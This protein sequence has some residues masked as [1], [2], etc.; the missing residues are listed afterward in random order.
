MKIAVSSTGNDMNSQVDPRFGRCNCFLF[1]ETEDMNVEACANQNAGLPN[2]A[3]IQ[4]AQFVADQG[5]RVVLTGRCG[6]K[7]LQALSS[8][9][10][11]LIEGQ[12]GLVRDVVKRFIDRDLRDASISN[13][14]GA[15]ADVFRPQ[16]G[17][18][19]GRQNIPGMGMGRR[20]G[21]GGG[22]NRQNR[23]GMGRGMGRFQR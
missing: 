4:S 10:I 1:I 6:P 2:G 8:A 9:G 3:G 12:T 19:Q 23:T 16:A 13:P 21:M 18:M 20:K 14:L 22:G 5:A 7:A 17:Q 15:D 11:R